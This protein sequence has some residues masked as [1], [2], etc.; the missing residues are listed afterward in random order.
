MRGWVIHKI[1]ESPRRDRRKRVCV[2]EAKGKMMVS[3][4]S[5]FVDKHSDEVRILV[6][7]DVIN[8]FLQINREHAYFMTI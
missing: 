8:V 4:L 1:Y 7:F 2:F 6:S 3:K 5:L